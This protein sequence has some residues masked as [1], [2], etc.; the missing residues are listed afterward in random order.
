MRTSEFIT[1]NSM[2]KTYLITDRSNTLPAWLDEKKS[3]DHLL[4][5]DLQDILSK[6]SIPFTSKTTKPELLALLTVELR[7]EHEAFTDGFS[8]RA[9]EFVADLAGRFH[10]Y[11]AGDIAYPPDTVGQKL[12]E[13]RETRRAAAM[14]D[15]FTPCTLPDMLIGKHAALPAPFRASEAKANAPGEQFVLTSCPDKVSTQIYRAILN[16]SSKRQ[17]WWETYRMDAVQL[18]IVSNSKVIHV[19]SVYA[20]RKTAAAVF[21]GPEFEASIA[22]VKAN[23]LTLTKTAESITL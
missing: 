10:G 5:K 12:A 4:V 7:K 17:G 9:L 2:S 20:G 14:V 15:K 19:Y 6:A 16:T 8:E 18:A 21:K 11:N 22:N 1:P 13:I 3:V 23:L